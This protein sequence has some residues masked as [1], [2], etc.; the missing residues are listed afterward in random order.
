M[1]SYGRKSI[2]IFNTYYLPTIIQSNHT[3]WTSS[4]TA[5]NTLYLLRALRHPHPATKAPTTPNEVIIII[6]VLQQLQKQRSTIKRARFKANKLAGERLPDTTGHPIHAPCPL[7]HEYALSAEPHL[8]YPASPILPLSNPYLVRAA[9]L[10]FQYHSE[11]VTVPARHTPD[12]SLH[13]S[14]PSARR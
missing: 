3:G 4:L 9:N 6:Q 14:C 13:N 12:S 1:T 2:L 7:V 11:T 10:R 8:A 5:R